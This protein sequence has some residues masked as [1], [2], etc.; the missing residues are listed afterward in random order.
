MTEIRRVDRHYTITLTNNSRAT[1]RDWIG[2]YESIRVELFDG[3]WLD[4]EA[5]FESDCHSAPRLIQAIVPAFDNRTNLAAIVHD[6][7]YEHWECFREDEDRLHVHGRHYADQAYLELMDQF[8]PQ[9][10]VGNYVRY[11]GVRLGG[12]WN[13]TEF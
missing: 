9:T 3:R 1:K 6:Y 12:W 11:I 10:K 7:L 4:I 5:G 8:S 2:V 13:W